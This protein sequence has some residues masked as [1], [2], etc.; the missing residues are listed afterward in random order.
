M[1]S[2]D[3]QPQIKSQVADAALVQRRRQQIVDAAVELFSR[4]GYYRTTVQEVARKAGVSIGLIYQYVQDKEDVLLLSILD[5]I[6][7]YRQEVPAAIAGL[8]DPLLRY[9]AAI[10][11]YCR[12][13][14]QR[15]L[16]TVLTYRSARSLSP[17]RR[18]LIKAA[19]IDT[20]KLI[21]DTVQDC[22]NAGLFR[23]IDVQFV[24][25]QLIM[26]AHAWAL[27]HWRLAQAY[28]FQDYL[29]KG[30]ELYMTACLSEAGWRRYRELFP[31]KT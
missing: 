27:K 12:V 15:R 20:N 22:V 17:E 2:S 24:T 13:V 25:H 21:S 6:D 26:F 5:V 11:A 4:Q 19:E 10:T 23:N 16:A 14:D 7:S 18:E 29:D 8:D 31:E 1:N 9:Q 30:I 28:G 3:L